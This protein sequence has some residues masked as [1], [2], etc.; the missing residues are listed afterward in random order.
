MKRLS[1]FLFFLCFPVQAAERVNV[2]ACKE[3]KTAAVVV[4]VSPALASRIEVT[5]SPVH[6]LEVRD[7][8][9]WITFMSA[10]EGELQAGPFGSRLVKQQGRIRV[11]GRFLWMVEYRAPSSMLEKVLV[12][13][14]R[15]GASSLI[16]D[17]RAGDELWIE[18][19]TVGEGTRVYKVPLVGFF[20]ALEE[21]ARRANGST[22]RERN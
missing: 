15:H 19:A 4:A 2:W 22:W 1:L 16:E 6:G 11:H 21:C 3:T 10:L 8:L 18:A 5:V 12:D 17:M 14:P 7:Y 20:S 13:F 9:L